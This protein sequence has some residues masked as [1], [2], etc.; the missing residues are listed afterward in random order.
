VTLL[1]PD[2][3]QIPPRWGTLANGLTL[4]GLGLLVF[5]V[6]TGVP[7]VD[8]GDQKLAALLLLVAASLAWLGW[9][10]LRNSHSEAAVAT[11]LVVV[12]AAGGALAALSAIAL[13]FP[14]MAA[15]AAASRWTIVPAVV[16]GAVGAFAVVVATV[17]NDSNIAIVWGGL[18]AVF[19]GIMVGVARRQAVEHAEQMTRLELAT[20]RTEVERTR[21]ELLAERNHLARELHDVLAHTLA[22]LSI[23]LEAF[24]TVVDAEPQASP[25]VREQ[26]QK[27]RRLVREG[28]DESR[29]A[30]RALRDDAVP[31]DERLRGLSEQ[32]GAAYTVSGVPR[33]LPGEV[34]LALFRVAQEALT[35]VM[36]H[37]AGAA[38]T[39]VLQYED[40]SVTLVVENAGATANG[41]ANQ[42]GESGGGF[43]LRGIGE[44]VALLGGQ[45]EAG[46]TEDGWRVTA[47]APAP[48]APETPAPAPT[49]SDPNPVRS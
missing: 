26:L 18:A 45:V 49:A 43:G 8:T 39:V 7:R 29:R 34:V 47:T 5:G 44:R 48:A 42:L 2:T 20:E 16:V 11:C 12:A 4:A 36:K 46:P 38:T 3:D 14:G 9:V 37:A 17:A 1:F 21:A 32:Q 15:L 40:E 13:I 41:R 35:N 19:T 10:F 28:L 22:A 6:V 24:A 25:A 30:V 27:T 31:L 33:P 23:Q